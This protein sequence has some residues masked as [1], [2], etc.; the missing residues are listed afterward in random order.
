[1]AAT[2]EAGEFVGLAQYEVLVEARAACLWYLAVVSERRCQGL[3]AAIY[4]EVVRRLGSLDLQALLIEVEL[5]DHA[6]SPESVELAQRRIGF[7][8]RQGAGLLGGIHYL[9]SVGPH[10]P[11]VP[12]HLMVHR[13][14]PLGPAEAFAVAKVV[15]GEDLTQTGSLALD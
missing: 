13:F 6:A 12:M 11:P 15:F 3:G 10:Q 4:Q 9:Q 2:D 7:Y 14:A 8:R 5:P 1:L